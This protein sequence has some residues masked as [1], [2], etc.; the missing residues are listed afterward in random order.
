MPV[1]FPEPASPVQSEHRDPG[2]FLGFFGTL[3]RAVLQWLLDTG[4]SS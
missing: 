4:K 2:I 3:R 1:F